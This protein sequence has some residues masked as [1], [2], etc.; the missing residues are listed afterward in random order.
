[1][2]SRYLAATAVALALG[3]GGATAPA[4][5][6]AAQEQAPEQQPPAA[7]QPQQ[8]AAGI[9]SQALQQDLDAAAQEL[10]QLR[11]QLGPD[12]DDAAQAQLREDITQAL[13]QLD[14][15]LD[16][17]EQAQVGPEL[18]AQAEE[19]RT[20]MQD[21]EGRLGA[22]GAI[23]DPQQFADS[24]QSIEEGIQPLT[25]QL[26]QAG[27]AGGEQQQA[28]VMGEEVGPAEEQPA[29]EALVGGGG[30][31]RE[32]APEGQEQQQAQ[33]PEPPVE[34][35]A[36]VEEEPMAEE[37]AA[38]Q[39]PE[40]PTPEQQAVV[41]GEQPAAEAPEEQAA[42]EPSQPAGEVAFTAEQL[43]GTTLYSLE[44]QE[45]GSVEDVIIGEAGEVSSVVTEVGGFLGIGGRQVAI[46]VAEISEDPEGRLVVNLTEQQVSELPEFQAEAEGPVAE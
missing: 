43:M 23:Q 42:A 13:Q 17:I 44:G 36:A 25:Q 14:G 27:Q 1:M 2:R 20:A 45:V 12:M 7:A 39:P 3:W 10:S 31:G 32:V 4:Y 29:P 22:E 33:A 18:T 6:Q 16:Q 11:Q 24:L 19:V 34:E 37:Q 35:Q 15:A 21:L 26:A 40:E 30:A 41:E 8:G 46:D 28:E 38:T 5:A 9:D